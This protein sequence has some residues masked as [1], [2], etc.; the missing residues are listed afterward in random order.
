LEPIPPSG[1]DQRCA[2]QP[3]RIESA[4][5]FGFV[6]D[7][8]LIAFSEPLLTTFSRPVAIGEL[9]GGA[10]NG[11]LVL[12]PI[13]PADEHADSVSAVDEVDDPVVTD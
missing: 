3:S 10:R 13:R 12:I 7:S 5:W 2:A 4:T 9:V 1:D 6:G 8:E 11:T